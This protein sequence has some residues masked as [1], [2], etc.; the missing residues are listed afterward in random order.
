KRQSGYI[1]K[2]IIIISLCILAGIIC[3]SDRSNMSISIVYMAN[4]FNWNHNTQGLV[5]SSFYFGYIL[6]QI[7]GGALT[8]KFGG[9][10]I[11][12]IGIG[13]GPVYPCFQSLISKWFPPEEQTRAVSAINV[14][15]FIGMAISMP[16]SNIL[17][18]S[19][20]GWESIFLVFA[21]I[22]F[23]W[24]VIWHFYGT[25]DPRDYSN[26]SKEELDWILKSK[27]T[28]YSDDNLGHNQSGFDDDRSENDMLLPNDQISSRPHYV[29]KI[30][31]KFILSRRE[32][33][34][35][36]LGQLFNSWGFF[37]LLNWLPFFY[38]EYFNTDINLVGYYT[39]LPY[40]SYAIVG[41]I[42]GCICD[43][44]I[45]QLK[46]PVLTVRRSANIIGCL[47]ITVAL[48]FMDIAPK[49]AGLIFALGNACAMVQAFLGVALTGWILG[50]TDNN[51]KIVWWSC[52]L[53][54]I[55]QASIFVSWA[56]G[57]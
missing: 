38:Y 3:Y 27:W 49:Y 40:F 16:I 2:R 24:S 26:I 10:R 39:A 34:A 36:I 57:E 55:L 56:G 22:G 30:P 13:E 45:Y 20:L 4:E 52:S 12:G 15:N 44:A 33:W 17:G 28:V 32:V 18:S 19:Q 25:S 41:Y 29:H 1:P 9:K 6:T 14:S 53:S 37:I 31:W 7:I 35:I 50:A 47:G 5:S 54:Y 42:G 46:I 48:L 21:I 43:Y 51:W 11:L 8:D 23:I